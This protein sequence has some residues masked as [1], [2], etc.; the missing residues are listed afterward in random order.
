MLATALEGRRARAA[1]WVAFTASMHP[2]M[3]GL[4]AALWGI[5]ELSRTRGGAVAAGVVLLFPMTPAYRTVLDR[6]PYHMITKWE[7]Y[8]WL[9]AV[10]PLAILAWIGRW[11]RPP[12]CGGLPGRPEGLETPGIATSGDAAN[13]SVHATFAPLADVCHALIAFQAL[14]LVLALAVCLPALATLSR[15]QPMRSLHFVY[16]LMFLFTGGLLGQFAIKRRIWL[17]ALVFAPLCGGMW[18]AQRQ[19]FPATS[20]LEWPWIESSNP[21]VRAFEWIRANTPKDAHFAM[22]PETM[23][24]PG[25]DQHGFRVIAQRSRMADLVKDSGPASLMPELAARWLEQVDAQRGIERFGPAEFQRLRAKYGVDWV[26]LS[27]GPPAGLECPC[28]RGVFVC[29]I[30]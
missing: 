3:G 14:F 17:W 2:L 1:A 8:E 13:K 19:L 27:S 6:L 25:E 21:W 10:A 18:F 22:D 23:A 16:I 24:L 5:Y 11:G 29:E 12:A 26:V 20:H 30:K 28:H 4:A 15:T 9:G 7:W